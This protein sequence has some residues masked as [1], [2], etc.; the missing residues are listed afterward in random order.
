M[1]VCVI[2]AV[3]SNF[4]STNMQIISLDEFIP[5]ASFY[6]IYIFSLHGS[7]CAG[8]QVAEEESI[9]KAVIR[10]NSLSLHRS[11]CG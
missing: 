10:L 3:Q 8:V 9:F 1:N 4:F 7:V 2:S 11:M 5:F 6:S